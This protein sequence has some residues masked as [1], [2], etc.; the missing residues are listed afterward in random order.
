MEKTLCNQIPL[1]TEKKDLKTL[2]KLNDAIYC[3]ND[4]PFICGSNTVN[5]KEMKEKGDMYC[6]VSPHR[7]NYKEKPN[8]KA[9]R[10]FFYT[11]DGFV[12]EK[13]ECKP[14]KNIYSIFHTVY[15][16]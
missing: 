8:T 12:T 3:P 2:G 1:N 10:P 9:N 5:G 11:E 14:P 6:Q 15:S 4:F 7:C 13:V 16:Y